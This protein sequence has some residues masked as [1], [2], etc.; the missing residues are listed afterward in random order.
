[1]MPLVSIVTPSFNQAA[2]LRRTIDSVLGQDYPHI[3]Y[4]VIDGG[5]TDGSVEILRSYGERVRW[6][7]EPDRGQ[8]D[9]INKG[10]ARCRGTIRGYLNS[11]DVLWPGAVRTVVAHFADQR[12]WDLIYGNAY[13]IDADDR[14]LGPLS[15]SALRFRPAVAELLHLPAG[16]VL[17][18]RDR[19]A[20]R[21]F[22]ADAALCDGPR[23]LA[24]H[25]PR[26]RPA[27]PRP[28]GARLLARASGDQDAVGTRKRLSRNPRNV[29]AP[30]GAR[31]AS[32]SI[33]RTGITVAV[34]RAAWLAALA[35]WSRYTGWRYRIRAGIRHD[36][37]LLPL[38]RNLL[39]A[40]AGVSCGE[41]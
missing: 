25:R 34:R 26:R 3:E 14:I 37:R 10:F 39:A 8:S 11:D 17:A 33:S 15:D 4:I 12:D 32:A 30:R 13:H 41:P 6:V 1:M 18:I 28:G 20:H 40:L 19:R 2:F 23:L 21:A 31:P 5:S 7:S 29:P 38:L 9:A 36:G 27:R 16:R 24:A 22:N 35:A